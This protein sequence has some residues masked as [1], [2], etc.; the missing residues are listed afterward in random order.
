MHHLWTA[1]IDAM[2]AWHQGKLFL[3]H[4]LSIDHDA[5]HVI[6]GVL[7]WLV[8]ALV[9]RRPITSWQP[10]LWCFAIVLWNETVDLWVEQWPDP[11]MQYGEGAKDLVLTILVPALLMVSARLR[12][13]L[14]RA[15]ARRRR[16]R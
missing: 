14:F 8:A 2:G 4:S 13:D 12:P 7:V 6:V 10:F 1:V 5:L 11:G 3:E 16:R 15:G 9:L